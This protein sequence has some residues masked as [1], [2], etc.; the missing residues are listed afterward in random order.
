MK[1]SDLCYH[2]SVIIYQLVASLWYMIQQRILFSKIDTFMQE[3]RLG[4]IYMYYT[5]QSRELTKI[6]TSHNI[7]KKLFIHFSCGSFRQNAPKSCK[8]FSSGQ[9]G[10]LSRVV[11]REQMFYLVGCTLVRQAVLGIIFLNDALKSL[12]S[13]LFRWFCCQLF[14]TVR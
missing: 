4:E 3:M 6:P 5:G 11:S 7:Q 9:I 8:L 13:T 10:I 1:N 12:D 14:K 2:Q